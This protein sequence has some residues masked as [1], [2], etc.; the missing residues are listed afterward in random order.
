VAGTGAVLV[1]SPPS[2]PGLRIGGSA[3]WFEDQA[4]EQ[5]LELAYDQTSGVT[6]GQLG[7][8]PEAGKGGEVAT[9]MALAATLDERRLLAGSVITRRRVHR[10]RAG[11]RPA[12]AGR[13]LDAADQGQ[14]EDAALPV[15]GAALGAGARG[16]PGALGRPRTGRDPHHP[17]DRPGRQQRRA[18]RV[19]SRRLPSPE[20]RPPPAEPARALERAETVYAITSLDT[21]D[22]DPA[23]LACW[24]RGH[25]SIEARLDWVRD[26]TF[27]EDHSHI[28]TDNG[29]QNVAALRTLAIN[30]LRLTG[31]TNIAAGLREHA[32]TPLLPPATLGLM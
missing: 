5:P 4:G 2:G 28:R 23:L 27:G 12:A 10:P 22:A 18:R 26:V 15:Q 16:R 7:C 8:A 25:W 14:P 11:R 20:D 17:G 24:V 6:L 3:C 9:A 29:P 19:L 13:T 30:A 1:S 31:H 21:R 32:R